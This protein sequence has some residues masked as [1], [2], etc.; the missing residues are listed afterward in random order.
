MI[1]KSIWDEQGLINTLKNGGVAVMPTDTLYGIVA[2]AQ[3]QKAVERIYKIKKRSPDK[4][5]IVLISSW[6]D[7]KKFDINASKFKIPKTDVPTSFILNDVAFRLPESED[8]RKLLKVTGPLVAPSANLENEP[9]AKNIFEAKK[10]FGDLI[11][12]Y[13]DGGEI[14]GLASKVI[15]LHN[16]GSVDILRE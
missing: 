16:D 3:D 6:N 10:Y 7:T 1:K 9:P 4:K 13:I 14:F 12:L 5:L 2:R 11:D 15:K 8:L